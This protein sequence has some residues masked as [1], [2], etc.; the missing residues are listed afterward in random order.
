MTRHTGSTFLLIDL[1]NDTDKDLLL[2]DVDYPNLIQ[3]MNG[4]NP[5]SAKM[6]T[7]DT[8]FPSY[9]KPVNLIAMPSAAYL[10]VDNDAI[11]DLIL[12]PFDP[13]LEKSQNLH[14]VWLYLNKG[15]NTAPDFKFET[16]NFLQNEMIDVGSG[17]YPVLA[18][19][20]GD[21]LKDLFISNYG[22]YIYSYYSAGNVLTISL[23]V[24][25]FT[26]QEHRNQLL[27]QSLHRITHNFLN[28]ED[29]QLTGIYLTF[30]DIDGDLD[31]DMILGYEEGDLW[32]FENIA[33]QGQPMD[34]DPP[35]QSF[36]DID[37]GA[38]S[39]PQLFDLNSDGLLDMVVGEENGNLNYYQNSGSI[40]NPVF[41]FITD[42]LGKVNV[43]DYQVSYTGFSTPCFFKNNR[44]RPTF[45]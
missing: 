10:D 4:G 9:D 18:D 37:V 14:S 24:E 42:S 22:D 19:Y 32:F 36:Q 1:D 27:S 38:F 23:L 30:G 44:M 5:D 21:G 28:L 6:I 13:G 3:L 31:Q 11:N 7:T 33:G 12:S 16:N 45:W 39:T 20:D 8:L 2:G 17:A 35:V 34:F 43:T 41:S 29:Y 15:E 40:S 26:F 25:C